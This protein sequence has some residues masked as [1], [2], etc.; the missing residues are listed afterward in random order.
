MSWSTVMSGGCVISIC[1][2]AVGDIN[3]F[4]ILGIGD[5]GSF[6]EFLDNLGVSLGVSF[7]VSL[8]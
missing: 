8:L 7:G 3:R 5:G 2:S 6:E 4:C 1:D